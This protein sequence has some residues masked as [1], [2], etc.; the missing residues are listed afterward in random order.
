MEFPEPILKKG[1]G[2][3][4]YVICD[5]KEKLVDICEKIGKKPSSIYFNRKYA[6]N[7][8]RIKNKTMKV[9]VELVLLSLDTDK[10]LT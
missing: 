10:E 7:A 6:C 9:C 8:I 1:F 3:N 4:Y 2:G 5:D